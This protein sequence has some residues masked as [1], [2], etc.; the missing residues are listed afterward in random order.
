[1][2]L[3]SSRKRQPQPKGRLS[4]CVGRRVETGQVRIALG[5]CLEETTEKAVGPMGSQAPMPFVSQEGS[6]S[7]LV[8]QSPR[9]S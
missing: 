7:S 8:M 9:P 1:M 4:G 2:R 6:S 5:L 3:P